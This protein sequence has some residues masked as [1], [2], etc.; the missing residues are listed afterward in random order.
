[1]AVGTTGYSHFLGQDRGSLPKG[2]EGAVNGALSLRKDAENEI[3]AQSFSTQTKGLPK[4][5]VSIDGHNPNESS[6]KGEQGTI[7]IIGITP[8]R[9]SS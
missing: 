9:K 8:G 6:Q 4:V 3:P 2:F 1:M 7:E 5:S